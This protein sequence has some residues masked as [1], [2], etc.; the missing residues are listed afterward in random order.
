[1]SV[2][3]HGRTVALPKTPPNPLRAKSNF[4]SHFNAILVFQ[5]ARQK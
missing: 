4:T 3:A 2:S 1:M 5:I